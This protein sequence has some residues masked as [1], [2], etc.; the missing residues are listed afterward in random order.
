ML[1]NLLFLLLPTLIF[2]QGFA[3]FF[4][5]NANDVVITPTF[6]IC[7]MGGATENDAAMQWLLERANGGD[8]VVLRSS[9]S[10]GYND[11]FYSDL[12]VTINS[13]ETLV[14]TST[15]G[16][17]DPYVL[18]KV[19]K[20]ELIWFAGGNQANYVDYFKDNALEDLL[21]VHVNAKNAPIGGTSAGM[22]I[23][24]NYYFSAMNGSVT[25]QE[26]LNNPYHPN[27]TIGQSDFLAVPLLTHVITDTHYDN[28]DRRGRQTSFIA[29][30][31]EENN[32]RTFGIASEEYVAVCVDASGKA[33]VFGEYPEEEDYA[34]FL[35]S[36]CDIA[37][38]SAPNILEPNQPLTWNN[39]GVGLK[40]YK[41]PATANGSNFLNITNWEIGSGGSWEHWTV[42]QGL[43][44][45]TAGSAPDCTLSI[46]D[47]EKRP[48]VLYPNPCEDY[49]YIANPEMVV[50]GLFDLQGKKI[51]SFNSNTNLR[52]DVSDVEAGYYLLQISNANHEIS[53]LGL[54]V[55]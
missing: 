4:T 3:S 48:V 53:T 44:A 27:A 47:Q 18:D 38:S 17:I 51:K 36:D 54:V 33:Y 26:M 28:P 32:T 39:E 23:L 31:I 2:A 25:S 6:G 5:G 30:I 24:G 43:L 19:S 21:N 45:V 10:D 16:A 15:E 1:K 49:F 37:F 20:A 42:N 14:I 8:V 22:A 12:G 55:K 11:Y 35:V 40:V 50:L 7:L 9:G 46:S 29:R 52:Y 13:V 41:V 34:Y